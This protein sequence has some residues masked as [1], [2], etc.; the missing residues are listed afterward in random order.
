MAF[1]ADGDYSLHSLSKH[2][3][4]HDLVIGRGQYHHVQAKN[5][6]AIDEHYMQENVLYLFQVTRSQ[7]HPVIVWGLS[8]I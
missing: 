4:Y 6:E 8:N 3:E 1:A 2:P 7:K 5:Y